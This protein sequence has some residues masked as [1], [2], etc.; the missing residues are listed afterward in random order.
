LGSDPDSIGYIDYG[1]CF[2]NDKKVGRNEEWKSGDIMGVE[3]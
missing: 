3:V 1:N 2:K